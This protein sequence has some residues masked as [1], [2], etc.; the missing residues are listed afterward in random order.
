MQINN[1]DRPSAIALLLV[2]FPLAASAW[3]LLDPMI[4]VFHG[5]EIR[6]TIIHLPGMGIVNLLLAIVLT[7]G[8]YKVADTIAR[9]KGW[10][11]HTVNTVIEVALLAYTM[12]T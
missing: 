8:Q 4:E 3:E 12:F 5:L 7:L 11:N 1:S 9:K 10:S 2:V 6:G